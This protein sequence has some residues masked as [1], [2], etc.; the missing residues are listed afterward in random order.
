[1]TLPQ[2]HSNVALSA[3]KHIEQNE[4]TDKLREL[5][6]KVK[7]LEL[8]MDISK[9]FNATLDANKLMRTILDKVAAV[10]DA[11]ACSFWMKEKHSNDNVCHVSVGPVKNKISGM[12]LK[13]GTGIVGW[14]IENKQNTVIFDASKDKRFHKAVD[15]KTSFITKSILCVP[16][17][18]KEECV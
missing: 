3:Q 11:E 16:L 13:Q 7:S 18:V 9:Q 10:L 8:L 6:A 15:H 1:M 12:R 14:V 5:E 2:N 17:I 4:D